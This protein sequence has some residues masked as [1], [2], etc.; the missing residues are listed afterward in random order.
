MATYSRRRSS[1]IPRP[2]R[3]SCPTECSRPPR[4]AHGLPF[5]S[6][7]GMDGGQDHVVLVA[8]AIRRWWRLEDRASARS[9][10]VRATDSRPMRASCSRSA[11]RTRA[12]SYSRSSWPAYQR[13]ARSTSAGHFSAGSRSGIGVGEGA[14]ILLRRRARRTRAGPPAARPRPTSHPS[15]CRPWPDRRPGSCARKPPCGRA[16]S[17]PSAAGT[18]GPDVGR[19]QEAQSAEFHEGDIAPRQLQFQRRA[20]AGRTEQRRLRRAWR[21]LRAAPAPGRRPSAPARPRR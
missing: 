12:S 11:R 21:P 17:R 2:C 8:R 19:L 10:S 1:S 4:S 7:G 13:K 16:D 5:L 9:G 14:P 15:A 3:C 6:L 20:M 18:A